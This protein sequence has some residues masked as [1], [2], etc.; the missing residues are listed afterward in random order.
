MLKNSIALYRRL[1][2]Y[3]VP[4]W[5]KIAL[6][7][8]CSLPLSL[9]TAGI[10]Y[11]VKP[12]LD[13]VFIKKDLRMLVLIPVAILAL[14]TTKGVL[15]YI[16]NY[17]LGYTGNRI[18]TDFRISLY[19]HLQGLSCAYFSRNP[20]GVIMSRLT[21]DVNMIQSSINTDVTDIFKETFTVIGLLFVLFAQDFTLACIAL[22]IMPW[23]IVPIM[24]FGKK[25]RRFSTRGQEKI[26]NIATF[27]HETISGFRIVKAFGMEEYGNRRFAH[28]NA[29]LLRI[30]QKRLKIRALSPPLMEFIGGLAGAT[31]IF[32]GGYK[33]LQGYSTPGTFFSFV[34]ALL[35][36]YGPARVISTAYQDIQE[37]LAAAVRVFEVIDTPPDVTEAPGAPDLQPVRGSILFSDVSFAYD[38]Q[39]VLRGLTLQVH[40]GET[41]A[42][43][44]MTGS[45][46]TTIARLLM[47]FY[48]P[49]DGTI[50]IDGHNIAHVTLRSLRSQ[51]ALVSQTP[52]MFNDTVLNNISYGDRTKSAEQIM[53]AA[54]SASAHEF[55][56]QLPG[57]YD[58]MIGEHGVK[59][60]GG[61]RQRIAIARAILKDAPIIILDEATSA[62]DSR[63]EN[64]I[65]KSLLTLIQGRTTIII[66]HRLS[67][68]RHADRI[69]VLAD[70][71][72]AEQG[73]H[74]ELFARG[75]D[76]ARLYSIYLQ[77]DRPPARDGGA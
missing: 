23:V 25:S 71:T 1:I 63:L 16:Y 67:T 10:A 47:R 38:S 60:S 34:A 40:P 66:A 48:D 45:G 54:R 11:L 3:V 75:G 69:V 15:A 42:L 36:L 41:V 12:A 76:Y 51:I 6:A 64:D 62:L 57:G 58:T 49:T 7:I 8:V 19:E 43:V 20:T 73:R 44:G 24:R 46:K 70:G 59:L 33:V 30:S 35:L 61:Q 2:P 22:M 27:M 74:D 4:H 31:I 13:E 32:Y 39:P 29:R 28:E 68:I 55:I 56:E 65:R 9:C 18:I 37:G 52:F 53:A 26:G 77:E 21:N 14:Y 5:K 50:A 72:I 17:L